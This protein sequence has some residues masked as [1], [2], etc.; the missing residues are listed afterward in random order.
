MATEQ[1]SSNGRAVLDD[2]GLRPPAVQRRNRGEAGG[3]RVLG[4]SSL[5]VLCLIASRPCICREAP[6]SPVRLCYLSLI[7]MAERCI[8]NCSGPPTSSFFFISLA[9]SPL[10]MSDTPGVVRPRKCFTETMQGRE[11][12]AETCFPH[13]VAVIIRPLP[14]PARLPFAA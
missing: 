5:K 14:Q 8:T 1:L 7:E 3:K 10:Q 6:A 12:A 11:P 13:A 2:R 9:S 4:Y